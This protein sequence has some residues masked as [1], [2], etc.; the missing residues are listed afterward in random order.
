MRAADKA[1]SKALTDKD[2][3]RYMA[4]VDRLLKCTKIDVNHSSKVCFMFDTNFLHA[5]S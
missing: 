1:A 4:V 2:R 5:F 3:E